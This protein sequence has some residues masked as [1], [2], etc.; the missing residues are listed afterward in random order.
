MSLA[1]CPIHHKFVLRTLPP[2][3]RVYKLVILP[4]TPEEHL[5]LSFRS[6]PPVPVQSPDISVEVGLLKPGQQMADLRYC[7]GEFECWFELIVP[8]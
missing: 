2:R 8:T 3:V 6:M 1:E 5:Y 7:M 4:R